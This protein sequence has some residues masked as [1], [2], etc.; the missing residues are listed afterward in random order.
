MRFDK[1]VSLDDVEVS[2]E[3]PSSS[4][5]EVSFVHRTS[6][7]ASTFTLKLRDEEWVC[8]GTLSPDIMPIVFITLSYCRSEWLRLDGDALVERYREI[9]KVVEYSEDYSKVRQTN[10][11]AGP[12][13]RK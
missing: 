12:N 5:A 11:F 13:W 9:N 6:R 8:L 3:M 4:R 10:A 2:V 7:I 1:V